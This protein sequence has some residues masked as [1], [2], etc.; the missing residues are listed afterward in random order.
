MIIHG[1][2]TILYSQ[3]DRYYSHYDHAVS[4]VNKD[5]DLESYRSD[6]V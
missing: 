1:S 4:Q 6:P 3:D 2:S 5:T